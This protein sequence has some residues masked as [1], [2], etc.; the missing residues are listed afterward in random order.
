MLAKTLWSFPYYQASGCSPA[1]K[2]P[3]MPQQSLSSAKHLGRPNLKGA[4]FQFSSMG[5]DNCPWQ[6]LQ[7]GSLLQGPSLCNTQ[8]TAARLQ[9]PCQEHHRPAAPRRMW[10]RG[11]PSDGWAGASLPEAHFHST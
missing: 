2:G 4:S 3:A 11:H 6:L 1:H 10:C 5:D 7:V 8:G 9:K